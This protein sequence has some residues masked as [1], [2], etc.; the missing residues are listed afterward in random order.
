MRI[1]RILDMQHWYQKSKTVNLVNTVSPVAAVTAAVMI[2]QGSDSC[3]DMNKTWVTKPG[4]A[5][6]YLPHPLDGGLSPG[7]RTIRS[8]GGSDPE[9]LQASAL[10]SKVTW[11]FSILGWKPWRFRR[12]FV[13]GSG[14]LSW[15]WQHLSAR[16]AG[17]SSNLTV[18]LCNVSPHVSPRR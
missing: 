8:R 12:G 7:S 18:W 11:V 15:R 16:T 2:F 17:D 14:V 5:P 4:F 6:N 10:S 9:P 13:R 1:R 3:V